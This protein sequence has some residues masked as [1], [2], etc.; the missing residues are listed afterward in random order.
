MWCYV[1]SLYMDYTLLSFVKLQVKQNKY[2]EILL[3]IIGPS[4]VGEKFYVKCLQ[5]AEKVLY[6][7]NNIDMPARDCVV[8]QTLK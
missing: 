4:H 1:D 2:C 3:V 7:I 5:Q 6:F 8:H